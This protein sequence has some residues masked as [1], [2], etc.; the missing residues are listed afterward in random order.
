[1]GKA[2]GCQFRKGTHLDKWS[3]VPTSGGAMIGMAGAGC[4]CRLFPVAE[5][6]GARSAEGA[7]PRSSALRQVAMWRLPHRRLSESGPMLRRRGKPERPLSA[8]LGN[9]WIGFLRSTPPAPAPHYVRGGREREVWA[10]APGIAPASLR[11]G[12]GAAPAFLTGARAYFRSL[13]HRSPTAPE[14]LTFESRGRSIQG[15]NSKTSISSGQQPGGLR[16][17]IK[18]TERTDPPMIFAVF[19]P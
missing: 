6:P 9:S 12:S 8:L 16:E 14:A 13:P 19:P 10:T 2:A 4:R 18:A 1:M 15:L 7:H 3:G 17:P 5:L 11:Y